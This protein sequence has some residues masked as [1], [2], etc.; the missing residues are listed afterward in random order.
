VQNLGKLV[1]RDEIAHTVWQGKKDSARGLDPHINSLRK[2][3]RS[4]R[5]EVKTVYGTG[6]SLIEKTSI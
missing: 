4:S 1:K 6:Y 3:L 2:K 5:L